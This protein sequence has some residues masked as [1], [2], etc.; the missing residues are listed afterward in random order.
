MIFSRDVGNGGETLERDVLEGGH[1]QEAVDEEATHLCLEHVAK[2]NPVAE[3]QQRVQRRFQQ[4]RIVR[5]GEDEQ[6]QLEDV[7]E[8]RAHR[9]LQVLHFCAC[10]T[11]LGESEDLLR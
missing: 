11:L 8:F 7:R 4:R 5:V 2:W 1:V 3:A 10:H 9:I 6:T